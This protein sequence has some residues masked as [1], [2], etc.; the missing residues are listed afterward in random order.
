MSRLKRITLC[1]LAILALCAIVSST[2]SAASPAWWVSGKLLASGSTEPVAEATEVKTPF[3][4]TSVA[5]SGE[6]KAVKIET[7]DIEGEKKAAVHALVFS[8]CVDLTE[9]TKCAIANFSTKPLSITLEGTKGNLKLNF[10]PTAGEE[11]MTMKVSNKGEQTCNVAGTFHIT[12]TMACT[13]PNVE[14]EA[15][16]HDL[17]FSATSGSKLKIGTIEVELAGEDLFWLASKA[18]WSAK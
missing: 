16:R 13:Y 7:G 1:L 4:I 12:G 9:P 3:T 8:E 11:V 2:A 10:K 5:E 18:N 6:C 15:E 14:T 17:L